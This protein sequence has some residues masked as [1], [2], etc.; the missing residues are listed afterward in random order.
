MNGVIN[1]LKPTG[2]SSNTAVLAVRRILGVKKA[3]HTGTLD[4]GAAGVLAV[5]VGKTTKLSD[6]LMCS[7]KEYVAEIAFGQK[8]DT[9]DSYGRVTEISE[10]KLLLS[11]FK[12]RC[13]RLPAA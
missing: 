11:N 2:M 3:G 12:A 6:F 9:Q 10:A 13:P 1:F 5:C 4:P 8:T 7:P